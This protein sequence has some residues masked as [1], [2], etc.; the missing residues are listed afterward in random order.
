MIFSGVARRRV[1]RVRAGSARFRVS[2][3]TAGDGLALSVGQVKPIMPAPGRRCGLLELCRFEA[4]EQHQVVGYHR[5]P[6]VGLEV[7]E[8]APSA[9]CSPIGAF[10]A[11]DAGLDPGA[12]VA[13]PAINP[14][15]LDHIGN[16]D[17][18]LLVEGDVLHAAR[19]R[20][21][22]IVAAGIAAI[23]CGLPRRRTAT[24]DLAI[25]H[26]QEAFGVGGI[27]GLDDDIE[28]QT[29]LAGGEVE[30]V[31]VLHATAT[32]DDDVGVLL[33]Q[34]DQLLA[35]RH[36]LAPGLRRGRLLRTRRSLWVMMRAISG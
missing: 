21:V 25:E 29:A 34:T 16:G 14:R 31:S 12:E 30:L 3:E 35:G 33:E 5:G 20:L 2:V 24:G 18:A 26:G 10:E 19:R 17:A 23:G 9:A 4:G 32:F 7:I 36:R 28:D 8:P 15:A 13:Q 22:E 1:W 11:G 6:D 27:A